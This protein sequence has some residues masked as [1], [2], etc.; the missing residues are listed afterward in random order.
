LTQ[1][2]QQKRPSY[3]VFTVEVCSS[4]GFKTKRPFK[5]GDYIY[6]HGE[7]C[8]HCKSNATLIEMIYAEALKRQ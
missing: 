8:Q 4:C 6:K 1:S 7:E 2:I 3:Q 5:P